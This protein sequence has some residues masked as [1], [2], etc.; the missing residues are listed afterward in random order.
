[1]FIYFWLPVLLFMFLVAVV[2]NYNSFQALMCTVTVTGTY[3]NHICRVNNLT[4]FVSPFF[5]QLTYNQFLFFVA[6]MFH[7]VKKPFYGSY[8]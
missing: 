7:L 4:N 2:L 8:N 1:M 3:H 6:L 5:I